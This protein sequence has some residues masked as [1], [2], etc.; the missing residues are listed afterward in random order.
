MN[1]TFYAE[2]SRRWCARIAAGEPLSDAEAAAF[3]ALLDARERDGRRLL[4]DLAGP[5]ASFDT[6]SGRCGVRPPLL[7]L[8]Q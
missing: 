2:F 1:A 4:G 8:E 6:V 5:D 3:R 7:D